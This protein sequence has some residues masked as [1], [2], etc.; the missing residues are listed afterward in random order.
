MATLTRTPTPA[1]IDAGKGILRPLLEHHF[2][3]QYRS[4][5]MSAEQL[6]TL[7]KQTANF[8]MDFKNKHISFDIEQ[9][10]L[11]DMICDVQEFVSSPTGVTMN[12]VDG[13]YETAMSRIQFTFLEC[14]SHELIMDYAKTHVAT[15]RITMQYKSMS[16]KE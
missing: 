2:I 9:L 5:C 1:D 15:H 12:I 6:A 4:A 10:W 11:G 8:K 3:I 14:V 7:S 16:T 13:T